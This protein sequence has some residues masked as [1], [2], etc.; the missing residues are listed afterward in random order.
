MSTTVGCL[1]H[2]VFIAIGT[3]AIDRMTGATVEPVLR[4][5]VGLA[6]AALVVL[7]TSN[8]WH[9]LRGYGQG[10][11][12]RETL[13]VRARTGEPPSDDGPMIVTGISRADGPA[14]RAPLTGRECVAYQYRMY[15]RTR[16][17]GEDGPGVRVIWWG[18]ACRPFYIDAKGRAVRIAAM[19]EILDRA[20]T[21][22]TDAAIDNARTYVQTTQFEEAAGMGLLSS[23]AT[24]VNEVVSEQSDGLR[25]DWRRSDIHA[26]PADLCIE[27][28]ILPPGAIV[29]VAGHWSSTR[30]AIVPE[31][32]LGG[33]PVTAVTG[34]PHALLGRSSAVPHTRASVGIA[35]AVMLLL[36]GLLMWASARGYLAN[37]FD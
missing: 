27:E 21:E 29:S 15:Q 11:A 23:A 6:A 22:S 7:G 35:G 14:L 30:H 34:S 33:A 10:D 26:D 1:V 24:L 25:R 3:F 28:T 17:R 19:P 5:W 13:L 12:S 8:A 36:G 4:P 18:L 32:G 20:F 37:L 9:L 16:R 31:G 2:L